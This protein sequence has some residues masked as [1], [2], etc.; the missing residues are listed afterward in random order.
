MFSAQQDEE[1]P[2]GASWDYYFPFSAT[3]AREDENYPTSFVALMRYSF[4]RPRDILTILDTIRE[5]YD[6]P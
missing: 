3:N 2:V 6:D 1:F 4:H 5:K